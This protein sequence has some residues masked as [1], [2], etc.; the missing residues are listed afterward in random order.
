VAINPQVQGC[1]NNSIFSLG[2]RFCYEEKLY[3]KCDGMEYNP[4]AQLCND[5]EL[6]LAMC[7]G[8]P[9]NPLLRFCY[10]G[11]L[12]DKCGGTAYDIAT[13]FCYGNSKIGNL[14]GINPQKSYNLDLYE[15]KPQANPNG[16]FLKAGITDSRDGKSYSAVLMGTQT[17]M[18]KNLNYAATNSKCYSNQENNCTQYGRLYNWATAMTVCPDGW[19][20]PSD[21]EWN[22]LMKFVNPSCS[23]NSDCANA[24]A[25]L[26]AT[27]GWNSY[28]GNS[29]NGT[30]DYGFSALPG[31][32]GNSGGS[33]FYNVNEYGSWWS[34]TQIDAS[35][36]YHRNM[37]YLN[38][39][40]GRISAD[41]S[42][43]FS[44]RCV[45]G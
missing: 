3:P 29:G 24:G 6:S 33:S 12:V 18:A 21:D 28:N 27:D 2:S 43:Y 10:N 1:C 20:L 13:Q 36:A 9:Y 19:H 16:I 42:R 8:T 44:V 38:A 30:D 40:V 17:W 39:N 11:T 45:K 7:G 35:Y 14:C 5:G 4:S 37:G 32:N 22:A 34:A 15:C 31:G 26:K 23:E 25:N 41:L